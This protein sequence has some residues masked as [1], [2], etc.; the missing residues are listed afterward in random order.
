MSEYELEVAKNRKGRE[1]KGRRER[2][3]GQGA[4]TWIRASVGIPSG[5]TL[6]TRGNIEI[7]NFSL[8]FSLR[9]KFIHVIT[10]NLQ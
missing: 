5:I 7:S 3:T 10:G 8:S 4:S 9:C 6:G 1:L 2:A